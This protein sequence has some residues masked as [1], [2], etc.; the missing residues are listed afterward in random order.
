VGREEEVTWPGALAFI[1]CVLFASFLVWMYP[2]EAKSVI[3]GTLVIAAIL[4]F[5]GLM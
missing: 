1:S 5:A 2:V 3:G 4:F